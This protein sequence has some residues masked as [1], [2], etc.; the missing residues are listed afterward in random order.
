MDHM[1]S[2]DCLMIA[3]L[4]LI[5][6]WEGVGRAFSPEKTQVGRMTRTDSS[7]SSGVTASLRENNAAKC[8][9]RFW[10]ELNLNKYIYLF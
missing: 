6:G 2:H 4:A 3:A 7:S 1:R 5:Q 8:L 10:A 9:E